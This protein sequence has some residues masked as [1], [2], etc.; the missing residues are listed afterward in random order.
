MSRQLQAE[1]PDQHMEPFVAVIFKKSKRGTPLLVL[2][3]FTYSQH[4]LKGPRVRWRCSTH[5]Y[6]RA[7]ITTEDGKIIRNLSWIDIPVVEFS[8]SKRGRPVIKLGKYRYNKY[9]GG[10]FR[11][12]T[13]PRA[14]WICDKRRP[15][16]NASFITVDNRIVKINNNTHN[17]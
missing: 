12:D 17:H 6:C 14:R 9:T 16:C 3:G 8:K 13:G 7:T 4:N 1:P 15:R 11:G 2:D 5:K 10:A